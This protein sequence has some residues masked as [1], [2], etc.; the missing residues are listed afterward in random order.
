MYSYSIDYTSTVTASDIITT[1]DLK[2]H[3]RVDH[4]DEDDFIEALR[5]AAIEYVESYCNIKL[6]DRTAVFY[7]DA[8]PNYLELPVGPVQSL[9]GIT[10]NTDR[11]TTVTLDATYYYYELVRQPARISFISPPQVEE[12][13]HNGVQIAI[14]VG[15]PEADIPKAILHAI[16]LMVGHW[17]ENRRQVV[18][19]KPAELPMGVHSLLNPFRIISEL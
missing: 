15:Y 10:Y 14:T 19:T 17:Y 9:S 2:D 5:E 4:T 18:M 16:R 7:T 13:T 1:A 12:Y 6:G 3:L 8:F 11:T